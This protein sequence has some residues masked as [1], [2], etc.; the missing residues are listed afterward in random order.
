ME[1]ADDPSHRA[2]DGHEGGRG[3][4]ARYGHMGACGMWLLTP[5]HILFMS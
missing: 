1:L 2:A 5:T 4:L 3:G